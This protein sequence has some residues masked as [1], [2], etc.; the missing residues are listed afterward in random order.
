MSQKHWTNDELKNKVVAVQPMSAAEEAIIHRML[1]KSRVQIMFNYPFFGYLVM[2]LQLTPDYTIDTAATDS[3]MFYYNPYFIKALSEPERTW[4][5]I[6]EVMHA[7]L[8]HIWRCGSRI[9]EKW[10]YA[11]DYAIHSIMQSFLDTCDSVRRA[12][13]RMPKNCLY[14]SKYNNMS[15][16]Q[17]YAALPE[18]YKET[19]TYG[20]GGDSNNNSSN[21]S[22]DSSN[23]SGKTPL[24]DHSRWYSKDQKTDATINQRTWDSRV[25]AAANIAAQKAQGNV[26]AFFKRLVDKI[27]RSCL[28]WRLILH[29]FINYEVNDFS[30]TKCD[31]RYVEEEWGDIKMPSFCDE[32]EVVKDVLFYIDTSGS[33][34][35]REL[36]IAYSEIIG[37]MEQFKEKLSGKLGFF[38]SVAYEP[39]PFESVDDIL[40]IVPKGCGGTSFHAIFEYI[41]EHLDNEE[42]AAIIILTDGYADWPPESM[43]NGIPVL[44]L[45]NNSDQI[46]KWGMHAVIDLSDYDE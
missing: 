29:N 44:W 27:T 12:S 8:K 36:T 17:I 28:D 26:P 23:S 11:C 41:N 15:A 9:P 33:I 1:I 19:A 10:N 45:I 35:D 31:N 38:E 3:K 5:I 20:N 32:Q 21:N 39:V 43:A 30:F 16:E 25:V 2:H 7:A 37:A 40:K 42:I 46:P 4:I 14:S 34:G 6:H 24:D 22:S 13:L 18:N